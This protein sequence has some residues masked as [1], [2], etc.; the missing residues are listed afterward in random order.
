MVF[1]KRVPRSSVSGSQSSGTGR[2]TAQSHSWTI[3][4]VI[5]TWEDKFNWHSLLDFRSVIQTLLFVLTRLER[6]DPELTEWDCT[7]VTAW[8]E[9][10]SAVA[11]HC[12]CS[13]RIR[14]RVHYRPQALLLWADRKLT[15]QSR[16]RS[17]E[18]KDACATRFDVF[19]IFSVFRVCL[20]FVSLPRNN[21]WYLKGEISPI[22]LKIRT[23]S[24]SS[25]MHENKQER[26][27]EVSSQ[28]IFPENLRLSI[29]FVLVF[30]A[31]RYIRDLNQL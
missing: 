19:S 15:M 22:L 16:N 11:A 1:R 2:G 25:R 14:M 29:L 24:I 6:K 20:Y 9:I 8:E 4:S 28:L 27:F 31:R 10:R 3:I 21:L 13:H 30:R 17:P 23:G 5:V 18:F 12:S 7:R 26:T